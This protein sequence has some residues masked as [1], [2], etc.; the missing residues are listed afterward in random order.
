MSKK[1]INIENLSISEDLYN[2]INDEA[3]PGTEYFKR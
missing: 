1:Y 2:F 3:I